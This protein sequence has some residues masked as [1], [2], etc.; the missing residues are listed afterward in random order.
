MPSSLRSGAIG[1]GGLGFSVQVF[2]S[3]VLE[4]VLGWGLSKGF[5]SVVVVYDGGGSVLDSGFGSG[6]QEGGA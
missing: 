2:I 5:R 4:K 3:R 6:L 1:S